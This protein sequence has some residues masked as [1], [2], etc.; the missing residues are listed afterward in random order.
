V[1]SAPAPLSSVEGATGGPS[2]AST[3]RKRKT[4][5]WPTPPQD[6]KKK[7]KAKRGTSVAASFAQAEK[8]DLLGIVLVRDNPYQTFTRA[9]MAQVKT[10]LGRQVDAVIDA[11][12]KLIPRFTDC[13]MRNSR[14][15]LSCADRKSFEWLKTI[16]DNLEVGE[17]DGRLRLC[18]A[19]PDEVPKLTRAEVFIIT[20]DP[21]GV[22][23]FL[24]N[25]QAQNPGL[26]T[27]RWALKHQQQTASSQLLVFGIDPES[28]AALAANDY[29]AFFRLGRVTFKVAQTPVRSDD[30]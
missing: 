19:T 28:V 24:R 5:V 15:T 21:P 11:G 16:L 3:G 13:G 6:T 14:L 2:G 27:E 12:E 30:T 29:H 4:E 7:K 23:R 20:G 10:E 9:E 18:L 26:H 25:I 17:G 22:P 1:P 8:D